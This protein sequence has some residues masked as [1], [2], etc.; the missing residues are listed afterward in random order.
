MFGLA[1]RRFGYRV[2]TLDPAPDS[3]AG[4][5]S[6]HEITAAYDD[7][8]ALRRFALGVEVVT[9]EFE[10]IPSASIDAVH[11]LRPVHPSAGVLQVCQNR[12]REK[13]FLTKAGFPCAR[14]AVASSAAEATRCAT[15]LG[16]PCVL[17][18]A[19]FGYDG[20][21]QQKIDDPEEAAAAFTALGAPRAVLEEWVAFDCE[22]SV[23]CARDLHGHTHCFPA[24]ENIHH[25]HILDVS[26]VPARVPGAVAAAA[27]AMAADLARVLEVVGL[28]AVE[29]FVTAEGDLLVN[30]MAPRPHNSGHFTFDACTTSQFD[31]QLRAVC[32][33]PLG[34]PQLLSPVVMVNIL[35]EAWHNG[36]PPWERLLEDP[37]L[38]LHLYGKSEARPGR[39]MGH[40]CVLHPDPAEALERALAARQLLREGR[41]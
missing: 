17:K 25:R 11:A 10:N 19:D 12:E 26:I 39:K 24:A 32:G 3:P 38:K 41:P 23:V 20:K 40:F 7:L 4:Q 15:E 27:R 8:E 16:T 36:P 13:A 21:G 2:H 5:V 6:D 30:E 33:L 37:F 22:I 18:T 31:Q 9:F 34:D 35:G 1:A 29:F 14:Y 28:L